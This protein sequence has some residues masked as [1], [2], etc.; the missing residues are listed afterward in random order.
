MDVFAVKEGPFKGLE[1]RRDK[2]VLVLVESKV[3]VG[4]PKDSYV[5]RVFDYDNLDDGK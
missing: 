5:G 3:R 1:L 2:E 4:D